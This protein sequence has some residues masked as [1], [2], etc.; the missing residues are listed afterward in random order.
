MGT[1]Y[2]RIICESL[3]SGED[4]LLEDI[5]YVASQ[6]AYTLELLDV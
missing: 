2:N 1:G 6:I 4:K 5:S 3:Q